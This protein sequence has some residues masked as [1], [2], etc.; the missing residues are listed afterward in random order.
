MKESEQRARRW[1]LREL[2][3]LCE[4]GDQVEGSTEA[5]RRRIDLRRAALIRFPEHRTRQ[6]SLSV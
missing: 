6:H 2:T 4:Q 5:A 1:V 3:R